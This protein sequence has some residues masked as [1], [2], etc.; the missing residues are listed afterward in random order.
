M[1][2]RRDQA[3]PAT[4]SSPAR[5][6]GEQLQRLRDQDLEP[7]GG[8]GVLD[9]KLTLGGEFDDKFTL[10]APSD[11]GR[12]AFQIFAPDLMA[13]FIDRLGT[14]DVEIIDDTDVLLRGPFRPV[15]P[16]LYAWLQD[17]S[18]PSSRGRCVAPRATA[19]ISRC[20]SPTGEAGRGRGR[21]A[22][23]TPDSRLPRRRP[24]SSRCSPSPETDRPRPRPTRWRR[25]AVG[26]DT[27]VGVLVR[28]R[29]APLSSWSTTRSGAAFGLPH[30]T[31][32][33]ARVPTVS[34]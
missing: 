30:L 8:P 31:G 19:T 22:V 21:R 34:S 15:E 33:S 18:R 14:F 28:R 23:Q 3:R 32:E 27:G 1:G 17:W 10:Y 2:I 9:Q 7:A 25:R 5:C 26:S 16:R 4:A 6:Q 29:P 12:D 20:S 11:Y 24:L 13:L